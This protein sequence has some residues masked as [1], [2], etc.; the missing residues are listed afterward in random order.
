MDSENGSCLRSFPPDS[1]MVGDEENGIGYVNKSLRLQSCLAQN[2]SLVLSGSES[3]G[4]VRAW[5]VLS[6]KQIGKIDVSD[7]S[8]V[9]SVVKWREGSDLE[10]RRGV[11]AAGGTE[12]VVKIYG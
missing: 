11:W 1:K 4:H 8:K 12:G 2:D 9:I 10:K 3:D 7:A 6:G 5:D